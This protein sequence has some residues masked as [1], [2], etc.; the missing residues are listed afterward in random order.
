MSD[1]T[2]SIPLK[3]LIIAAF[4]FFY[5]P[6]LKNR[7]TGF[8]D[9][10]TMQLN[11]IETKQAFTETQIN[12]M[13]LHI[14]AL[15]NKIF[16][17]IR[18]DKRLQEKTVS[19]PGPPGPKGEQGVPGPKGEQGVPGP[20]GEQGVPGP[21]GEQGVPGP[22]GEQG[23]QG[24]KGDQGDQGPKGDQGVPGPKGDQ[25]VPGPKGEQG[26]IG[27]KG[28]QGVPGPKGE[29]GEESKSSDDLLNAAI[30]AAEEAERMQRGL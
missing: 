20:K 3:Y 14:S 21:K 11:I 17:M 4:L 18:D 7:N 8:D 24:P 15:E 25:G 9:N 16:D 23:D 1:S 26:D 30:R 12:Q 6:Y 10:V 27:P 22:K 13:H 29:Q 28:D 2:G 19:T 5:S